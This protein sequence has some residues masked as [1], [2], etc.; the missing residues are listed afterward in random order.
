MLLLALLNTNVADSTTCSAARRT[1]SIASRSAGAVTE[2]TCVRT[3]RR[4]RQRAGGRRLRSLHVTTA[5]R[6]RALQLSGSARARGR[7]QHKLPSC[8]VST[9]AAGSPERSQQVPTRR[10]SAAALDVPVA[11]LTPE[12]RARRRPERTGH[13]CA[14]CAPAARAARRQHQAC[15]HLRRQACV[16]PLPRTAAGDVASAAPPARRSRVA[17]SD[18]PRN[19]ERGATSRT[20]ADAARHTLKGTSNNRRRRRGKWNS[21]LRAAP[22]AAILGRHHQDVLAQGW[23]DAFSAAWPIGAEKCVWVHGVGVRRCDA[24]RRC[25]RQS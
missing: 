23:T 8:A 22:Q 3:Q 16:A 14:R 5:L 9:H 24:P 12:T 21:S 13:A 4:C 10:G 18:G 17:S 1:G 7:R 20:R 15:V 11:A 2:R 19:A 6:A 25:S